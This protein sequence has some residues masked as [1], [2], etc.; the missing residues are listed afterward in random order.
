[1]AK[2]GQETR[3]CVILLTQQIAES[4]RSVSGFG[5]WP[6]WAR[7]LG[8][9]LKNS[10]DDMKFGIYKIKLQDVMVRGPVRVMGGSL[11]LLYMLMS[12]MRR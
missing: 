12:E 5:K 2:A 4:S 11:Q 10:L 1:M 8:T 9:Q 3:V 6:D 7:S